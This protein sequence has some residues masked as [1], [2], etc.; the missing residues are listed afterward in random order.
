[1]LTPLGRLKV[2][3]A[4]DKPVNWIGETIKYGI[5]LLFYGK[6]KKYFTKSILIDIH[7]ILYTHY[8]AYA[9]IS[10]IFLKT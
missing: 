1:M 4:M 5:T 10:L 2:R 7:D 9:A 3:W 8:Y 6:V